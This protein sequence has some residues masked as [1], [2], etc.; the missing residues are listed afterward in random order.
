MPLI[1]PP[2][3]SIMHN[4]LHDGIKS[5]LWC[6][7]ISRNWD[8]HCVILKCIKIQ[9]KSQ[10]GSRLVWLSQEFGEDCLGSVSQWSAG[11]ADEWSG[12]TS[13]IHDFLVTTISQVV[14]WLLNV[15]SV[16]ATW[17]QVF[18]QV[19]LGFVIILV[20]TLCTPC[21]IRSCSNKLP[22]CRLH[23]AQTVVC[24]TLPLRGAEVN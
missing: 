7:Q 18:F 17:D 11:A 2:H 9:R 23:L 19:T 5:A 8:I 14:L 10:G 15:I 20:T 22:T 6:I 1:S 13:G 4:R 16:T 21:T 24:T 3:F 12:I